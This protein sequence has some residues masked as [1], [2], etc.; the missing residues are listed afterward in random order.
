MSDKNS[1]NLDDYPKST[2]PHL[3]EIKRLSFEEKKTE[4]EIAE[5]LQ[6]DEIDITEA[7]MLLEMDVF[8]EENEDEIRTKKKIITNSESGTDKFKELT[9]LGSG[10]EIVIGTIKQEFVTALQK[11][12][13]GKLN[14]EHIEL[15]TGSP[16]SEIDDIWHFY[17]PFEE[18]ELEESNGN[19]LSCSN[20]YDWDWDNSGDV[21]ESFTK[22]PV[23]NLWKLSISERYL[24]IV[25]SGEKGNWGKVKVPKDFDIDQLQ[26]IS[27][28]SEF[29]TEY[30]ITLG[31][32]YLGN[33]LE[34]DEDG[35]TT[36]SYRKIKIFDIEKEEVILEF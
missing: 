24:L 22:K 17:G 15:I 11:V 32:S 14:E 12:E 25:V 13:E 23:K 20:A 28:D 21:I 5:Q 30:C 31:F 9:V 16:W 8:K 34:W 36:G 6:I 33:V 35:E 4:E 29:D 7:V 2:H 10:G 26:V 3:S 27:G 19:K 18:F 1:L